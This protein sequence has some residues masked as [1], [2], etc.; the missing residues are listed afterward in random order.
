MYRQTIPKKSKLTGVK[1]YT[2][3][4]IEQKVARITQNKEPITDSAPLNY[5]DRKDGVKPEFNIRTDKWEVA[6]EAQD[7]VAELHRAQRGRAQGERT[8]D[9]MTMEDKEAFHKK[10]PKNKFSEAWKVEKG[11]AENQGT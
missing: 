3:E 11:G 8:Y 9:T 4:T 1:T 5:T 7:K 6:A 2:G 10:Y